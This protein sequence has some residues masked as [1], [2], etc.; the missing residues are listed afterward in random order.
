MSAQLEFRRAL[1]DGDYRRLRSLHSLA[2][3]HL[4]APETDHAAEVSLHMAR[5]QA[6]WLGDRPRCY[7]HAWLVERDLPSQLPD[8][9]KPKASRLYP[10]VVEAVFVSANSNSPLVRPIAKQAQ[11]AM[12]AA[13]EDCFA[14]GDRDPWLVRSRMMEARDTTFRRLLGTIGTR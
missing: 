8:S 12:C 4:P 13:V 1:A 14:N 10:R 5:T 3:P 2:V 11:R 9:L 6:E 7:S